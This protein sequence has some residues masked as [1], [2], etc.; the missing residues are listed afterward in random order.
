M[1]LTIEHDD[2]IYQKAKSKNIFVTL[3][4]KIFGGD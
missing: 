3:F 1:K 2:T 4:I